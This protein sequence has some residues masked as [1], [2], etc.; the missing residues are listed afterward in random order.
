MKLVATTWEVLVGGVEKIAVAQKKEDADARPSQRPAK[1]HKPALGRRPLAGAWLK[2]C[3]CG[4]KGLAAQ[5]G[6][7][8]KQH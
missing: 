8:W 1:A 3:A 7:S 5:V 6:G 2:C 4:Y